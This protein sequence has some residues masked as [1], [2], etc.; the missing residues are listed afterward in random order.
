MTSFPR[1]PTFTHLKFYDRDIG[2]DRVRRIVVTCPQADGTVFDL[3]DV[4][5]VHLRIWKLNK[6]SHALYKYVVDKP[7]FL[8]DRGHMSTRGVIQILN[9]LPRLS[10]CSSVDLDLHVIDVMCQ[11]CDINLPRILRYRLDYHD[12]FTLSCHV[13]SEN[14]KRMEYLRDVIQVLEDTS[15]PRCSRQ[16]VSLTT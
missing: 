4:S 3:M 15:T 1:L 13:V 14:Y 12:D 8:L 10:G 9:T 6:L 7:A 2:K 11:N 5:H 16:D